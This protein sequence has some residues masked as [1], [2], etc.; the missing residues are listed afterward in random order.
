MTASTQGPQPARTYV[1]GDLQIDVSR[2]RVMR[3]GQ[4]LALPRLSFDLLVALIETAPAVVTTEHLL[5]RVWPGL[6]VNTE[7]VTQRVK[8]LRTAL[9][10]D[11]RA[12]RYIQV[13]R[14]RGY[15][16]AAEVKRL[17]EPA[18]VPLAESTPA[19]LA[20]PKRTT[21]APKI[22]VALVIAAG[23][24]GAALF[25]RSIEPPPVAPPA[26]VE[27]SIAV[28]PFKNLGAMP[29]DAALALGMAE[30]VLHQLSNLHDLVVIARTSSFALDTGKLDAA[31]IG[32]KLRARYILEG[33]VQRIG[34]QLR[35]T[36][37]LVDSVSGAH[38]WSLQVDRA[39]RD[40]FAVQDEIA[41]KVAQAM[42]LSLDAT[43]S[44]RIAGRGTM[45]FDAYFEFL[46]ARDLLSGNRI[47]DLR[48]AREHLARAIRLDPGFADAMVE[49]AG[50]DLRLVEFD[51]SGDR[52]VRFAAAREQAM[53]SIER[54][55]ALDPQNG[56]AWLQRAYIHGFT[57]LAGAEADYRR[58]LA[59]APSA[60]SGYEGLAAVLYQD[61]RR[62]DEALAAIDRARRLDPLEP[63]HDVTKAVFLLYGRS[64]KARAQTILQRVLEERP[65]YVPALMRLGELNLCCGDLAEGVRFMELSV[66]LDPD[67]EW[68]RR[69]LV[70]AYLDVGDVAA[71]ESV[72]RESKE[73]VDARALPLQLYREEWSQAGETAY[74]ALRADTALAFDENF[75][76]MALRR[77]A[78]ATGEIGDALITLEQMAGVTWDQRGEPSLTDNLDM[79]TAVAGVADLLL[80]GGQDERAK[81]LLRVTLAAID[82]EARVLNRGD[83]W[84]RHTRAT[85]LALLGDADGAIAVLQ[86]SLERGELL[87]KHWLCL[88]LDPAFDS[89]RD[90]PA[91]R[92]VVAAVEVEV[93]RQRLKLAA[94]RR[95]GLIPA[96]G[97]SRGADSRRE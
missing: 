10:D 17:E 83:L 71:A 29:D 8:L 87:M 50:A 35:V 44:S 54:A 94:M 55:I 27:R 65:Q 93:G 79:K 21:W 96:R 24:A 75:I 3:N 74:D 90:R 60:A 70:S 26:A 66:K 84:S 57:D 73:V 32:E 13:V 77:H 56:R 47:A 72:L 39:T 86:K 88:R 28:L 9:G 37:Q 76:S 22:A 52:R 18:S 41:M 45:D 91:F 51:V 36:A 30:T 11:P 59:L 31:R 1:V 4:Q 62:H 61:P 12:P 48:N 38:V 92:A 58:G 7:T 82:G 33:S 43:E 25:T 89:L 46:Q 15:R 95:E 5:D 23:L 78:R 69:Y 68:P 14:G 34:T 97:Q 19:N 67:A 80:L 63:A 49:L 40:V 53:V 42:E 2:A 64:D 6:V 81:R 16:L 20:V 85:S